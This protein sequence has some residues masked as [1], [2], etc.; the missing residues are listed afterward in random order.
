[1]LQG[2]HSAILSTFIKLLFVIKI[3]VC[4]LKYTLRLN[5][6]ECHFI[7]ESYVRSLS[8]RSRRDVDKTTV[9][10]FPEYMIFILTL[11]GRKTRIELKL[12]EHQDDHV[13]VKLFHNGEF[14][15]YNDSSSRV[16]YILLL[17]FITQ[18]L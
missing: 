18:A 3:F 1:M 5:A 9:A 17:R 8:V 2:E 12:N 14:T 15:V 7:S 10:K 4:L 6:N 13:P 16:S 11:D